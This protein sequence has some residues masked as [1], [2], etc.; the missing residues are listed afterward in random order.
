MR[1]LVLPPSKVTSKVILALALVATDVALEWVLVAVAAHVDG[2]EDVVGEVD[3]TVLAVMENVG[4]L[5]GGRLA[6]G[7]RAG[8]AV[9]YAW[10]AGTSAVLAARSP[11]GTAA[12]VRRGPGL[13]GDRGRRSGMSHAG[14]DGDRSRGGVGLLD[15]EGFFIHDRLCSRRRRRLC[16][17]LGF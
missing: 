12:A 15:Q 14:R 2:V 5:N 16:L 10:S 13:G 3:V 9:G 17:G 8:L 6:W 4:V 7:R 11:R 1:S